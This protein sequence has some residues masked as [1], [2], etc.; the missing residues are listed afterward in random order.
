MQLQAGVVVQWRAA[1]TV[2]GRSKCR[3]GTCSMATA[4]PCLGTS[5]HATQQKRSRPGTASCV[6]PGSGVGAASPVSA[7]MVQQVGQGA[8]SNM[9]SAQSGQAVPFICRMGMSVVCA[10]AGACGA[11]WQAS[12]PW[13]ASGWGVGMWG[14]APQMEWV[15][16]AGVGKG[17]KVGQGG[18][19]GALPVRPPSHRTEMSAVV[20]GNLPIATRRRRTSHCNRFRQPG[21]SRQPTAPG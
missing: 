16:G 1:R 21:R 12:H 7:H 4:R 19:R 11:A 8:R 6:G 15:G 13:V 17:Q 18:A 14:P 10:A 20:H 5:R 9:A 2:G 3:L